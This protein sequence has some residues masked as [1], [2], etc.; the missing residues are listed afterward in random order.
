MSYARQVQETKDACQRIIDMFNEVN[1]EYE[2]ITTKV[3]RQVMGAH[4]M[5][6]EIHIHRV[7]RNPRQV[8]KPTKK[9]QRAR[10]TTQTPNPDERV[11]TQ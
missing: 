8:N 3:H 4:K 6:H 1:Y 5:M 9:K 7:E 11:Q 10:K 2:N